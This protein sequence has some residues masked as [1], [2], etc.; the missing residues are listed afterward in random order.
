MRE[1]G[2]RDTVSLLYLDLPS[3]PASIAEARAALV[4]LAG[5]VPSEALP[6]LR[7]LV[8]EVVT[9]AVRHTGSAPDARVVLLVES[10]PGGVRIEVHD[11]GSGFEAPAD[12][13]PRPEGTSGWGLYLVQKLSRRWGTAAEPD[14]H[15]WFELATA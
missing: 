4:D 5:H 3:E 2:R 14:S 13:R 11:Q 15:V 9:N 7:L 1:Q 6:N 12:P 10:C 8:S